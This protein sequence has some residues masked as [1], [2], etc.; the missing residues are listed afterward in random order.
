VH[1][2]GILNVLLSD[3]VPLCPRASFHARSFTIVGYLLPQSVQYASDVYAS[4]GSGSRLDPDVVALPVTI[5]VT[6]PD[7]LACAVWG[8]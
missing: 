3:V 7:D 1:L 6:V 4:G 5:D 8:K 2:N